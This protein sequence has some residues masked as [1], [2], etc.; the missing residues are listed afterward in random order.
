MA[1]M[2]GAMAYWSVNSDVVHGNANLIPGGLLDSNATS[3]FAVYDH[4]FGSG[5][6][7]LSLIYNSYLSF[8]N[9]AFIH[10]S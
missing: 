2:V 3:G 1:L 4:L 6:L 8:M 10:F 9:Y 7:G 5:W